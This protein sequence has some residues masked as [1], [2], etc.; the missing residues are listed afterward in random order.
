MSNNEN[1]SIRNEV[2]SEIAKRGYTLSDIIVEW[3]K[4]IQDGEKEMTISNLSNK[5]TRG[6]I[7]YSE[8][9]KIADIIGCSLHW[10]PKDQ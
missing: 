10:K 2:K 1:L 6:T 5:L 8:I 7:K 9:Q 4:L 3:N